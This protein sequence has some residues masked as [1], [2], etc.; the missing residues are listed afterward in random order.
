M[1]IKHQQNLTQSWENIISV[2][3]TIGGTQVGKT[4]AK[5]WLGK[6]ALIL[7]ATA[8][9]ATPAHALKINAT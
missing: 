8:A 2:A 6:F 3:Q 9:T 5:R 4:L 1:G 7:A